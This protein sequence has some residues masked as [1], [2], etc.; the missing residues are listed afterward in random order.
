MNA[1]KRIG[2]LLSVVAA[3]SGLGCGSGGGGGGAPLP[4]VATDETPPQVS[5][6][7]PRDGTVNAELTARIR[8][9]FS[10]AIDPATVDTGSFKVEGPDG[11]LTGKV[12]YDDAKQE[13]TFTPARTLALATDYAVTVTR[14]IKDKAG[15]PLAAK[16]SARFKTRDGAWEGARDIGN[17]SGD[18]YLPQVGVDANGD[19][20]VVWF[21]FDGDEGENAYA[22]RFSASTGWDEPVAIDHD[23]TTDARLPMI[24]LAPS[25]DAVVVWLQVGNEFHVLARR[26]TP[27]SGFGKEER[28]DREGGEVSNWQV[29]IDS[30][31]S[32]I[33]V[34]TQSDGTND[35]LWAN[36]QVKGGD[37]GNAELIGALPGTA[38]S[39]Q[40]RMD[41]SGNAL[42][43]WEQ[44]D[45]V[46]SIMANTYKPG[47]GWKTAQAIET[48]DGNAAGATMAMDDSGNALVVWLQAGAFADVWANR[49]ES[50]VGFGTA[51]LLEYRGYDAR[52]PQLAMDSLGNAIVVWEQSSFSDSDILFN[53]FV[54]GQGFGGAQEVA[55][56]AHYPLQSPRIAMDAA[57]NA[58]VAFQLSDDVRHEVLAARYA[59][60]QGFGVPQPLDSTDGDGSLTHVVMDLSGNAFVIWKETIGNAIDLMGSRFVPDKGFAPAVLI[61][62]EHETAQSP[63]MVLD[64]HGHATIVWTNE[65]THQVR[66]NQFR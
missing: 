55:N 32:A 48:S 22:N 59:V 51:E 1:P 6:S 49:Y 61:E 64:L 47:P 11:L 16:F 44:F 25:G 65:A 45:G 8:V 20:M 38:R 9:K 35:N 34:W 42:V 60:G 40:I 13:A 57:G 54:K 36:R 21:S 24:A 5:S 28:I 4:P 43:I 12:R 23:G 2:L 3:M 31:G 7:H 19:A 10:E 26:Y 53:R 58:V 41:R 52:S 66:A 56:D 63:Q 17:A 18:P 37:W 30:A 15:N 33:A 46:T 39:P 29:A 27:G 62:D 50:G 14:T